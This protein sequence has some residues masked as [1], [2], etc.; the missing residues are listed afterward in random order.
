MGGNTADTS[1]AALIIFRKIRP[2]L[3]GEDKNPKEILTAIEPVREFF[4]PRELIRQ[5]AAG[6]INDFTHCLKGAGVNR[7]VIEEFRH[8]FK[9]AFGKT[10]VAIP[11]GWGILRSLIT[12]YNIHEIPLLRNGRN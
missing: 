2:I 11:D 10:G 5:T 4:W 1:K 9:A 12:Q 8:L 6:H 7:K 3:I